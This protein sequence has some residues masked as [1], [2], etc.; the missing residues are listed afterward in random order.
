MLIFPYKKNCLPDNNLTSNMKQLIFP[1][2]CSPKETRDGWGKL[3]L[4]CQ[5]EFILSMGYAEFCMGETRH[6]WS[7]DI[8]KDFPRSSYLNGKEREMK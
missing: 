2:K 3:P 1:P 4:H 5:L 8:S 6:S 7:L